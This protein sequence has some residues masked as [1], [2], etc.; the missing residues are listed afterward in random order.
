MENVGEFILEY[1]LC[2]LK[3]YLVLQILQ[4]DYDFVVKKTTG[5]Y[6]WLKQHHARP[7]PSRFLDITVHSKFGG[8]SFLYQ[9]SNLMATAYNHSNK[10]FYSQRKNYSN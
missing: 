9:N 3:E 10:I 5:L 1:Y 6:K 7:I 8:S 4:Y 2:K